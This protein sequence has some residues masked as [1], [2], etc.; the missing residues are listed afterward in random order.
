MEKCGNWHAETLIWEAGTQKPSQVHNCIPTHCPMKSPTQHVPK[1]IQ[2]FTVWSF[3]RH[4]PQGIHS[5][6]LFL[7]GAHFP[8]TGTALNFAYVLRRSS[9]KAGRVLMVV[10]LAACTV[11][12]RSSNLP[13]EGGTLVAAPSQAEALIPCLPHPRNNLAIRAWGLLH[14]HP[15]KQGYSDTKNA[16]MRLKGWV[17]KEI[18]AP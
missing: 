11:A 6:T 13:R 5:H 9:Q 17:E 3:F 10:A 15:W 8:P 4:P 2:S 7:A 16:S 18:L 14:E 1:P 12:L